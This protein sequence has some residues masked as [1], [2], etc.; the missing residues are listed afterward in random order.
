MHRL[1]PNIPA[2]EERL[3]QLAMRFRST[4]RDSK[5]RQIFAEYAEAVDRLI[6]SGSWNEAPAPEDQ[7]PHDYM[8]RAFFEFWLGPPSQPCRKKGPK[9]KDATRSG[10]VS[11][12]WRAI[13][14]YS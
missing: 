4:R 6:Q 14:L 8:P 13:Q 3:G 10:N 11:W 5:R 7:L 12:E 1:P 9:K 2:D